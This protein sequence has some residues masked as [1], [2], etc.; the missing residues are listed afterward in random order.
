MK[1]FVPLAIVVTALSIGL[2][3]VGQQVYRQSAYD[4]QVQVAHDAAA[5]ITTGAEY[6][7]SDF[8]ESIVDMS[9]SLAPFTILYTTDGTPIAGSGTLH[10]ASV[11]RDPNN[12]SVVVPGDKSGTTL[13]HIPTSDLPVPPR[14]VFAAASTHG[15]DRLTWQP[16]ST[17]RFAVVVVP[18]KGGYA[19][20][21]RS[22]KETENRT[23]KLGQQV[24]LGWVLTMAGTL[25]A[26]WFVY[27]S[28]KKGRA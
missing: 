25:L 17:H 26:V 18:F 23:I 22:L 11:V 21:G 7:N 9:T 28:S 27:R 19:L 8:P 3:S 6:G 13:G 2:Y 5:A 24:L 15:E 14:G 1:Q 12:V 4:P 16:D 20:A 10:Y